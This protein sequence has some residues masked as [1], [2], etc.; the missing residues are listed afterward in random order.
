[1]QLTSDAFTN[2]DA[3]PVRFTARGG[4][5]SPPLAWSE[6]PAG[7]KC[8]ALVCIDP[9]APRGTFTHW[10][11]FNIPANARALKEG[12]PPKPMLLD[13]EIQG[14]NDLGDLGYTGPD[15]PAGK[16]HRYFFKLFALDT[17]FDFPPGIAHAELRA[18]T[19]GHVL[20]EAQLIGTYGI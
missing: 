19:P 3:I 1:M 4:N 2:N 6:P 15:P 20:A 14:S 9:D 8:F 5:F 12:I 10:V 17:T 11:I 18:R 7:T 13:G 16:P